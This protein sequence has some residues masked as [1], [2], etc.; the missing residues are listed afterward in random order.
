MHVARVLGGALVL[1]PLACGPSLPPP[2]PGVVPDGAGWFCFE[3]VEVSLTTC[4]RSV[5]E[6]ERG[7]DI[8]TGRCSLRDRAWCFTASAANM[9]G[10]RYAQCAGGVGDCERIRH[11][12]GELG[13]AREPSACAEVR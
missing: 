12:L 3:T 7:H 8:S 9:G 2:T 5:D 1:A 10:R 6:C 13:D 4:S 11:N